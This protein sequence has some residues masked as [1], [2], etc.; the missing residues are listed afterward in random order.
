MIPNLKLWDKIKQEIWWYVFYPIFP[1]IQKALIKLHIIYHHGR[2]PWHLGWVAKGKTLRS[3]YKYV[4]TQ[5]FSNHFIAWSDDGQVLSLRK[6]EGF[7]F[8]YHL[9][10]F[11]DGE[12]RGHYEETPESHPIQ[13]FDEKVFE[14]KLQEFRKWLGEWMTEEDPERERKTRFVKTP[15]EVLKAP[16]NG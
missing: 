15:A 9:R 10:V 11:S 12:I 4:H 2:Q 5:G 7:K 8:Q 13:H 1:H 3:F 14:P 6:R 16:E